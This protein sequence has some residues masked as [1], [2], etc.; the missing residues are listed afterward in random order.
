MKHFTDVCRD[1]TDPLKYL[2]FNIIDCL[3]NVE[4]LSADEIDHLLLEKEKF[5]IKTFV[6]VHKGMNSHHDLH[7]KNRNE[8]ETFD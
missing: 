2:K 8:Q 6:T 1:S 4:D 3:D 5:W 7:R